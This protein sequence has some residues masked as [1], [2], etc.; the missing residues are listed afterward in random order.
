MFS[1]NHG[2]AI[3][4]QKVLRLPTHP[5]CRSNTHRDT[6]AV[7]SLSAFLRPVTVTDGECV[8]YSCIQLTNCPS[9]ITARH[10]VICERGDATG[11]VGGSDSEEAQR[12]Q[13][14]FEENGVCVGLQAHWDVDQLLMLVYWVRKTWNE[15][16]RWIQ[17]RSFCK[18]DYEN[19]IMVVHE[20]TP[21]KPNSARTDS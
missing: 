7:T 12:I 6:H 15:G 14:N 19:F 13:T 2:S 9:K 21:T 3:K 4:L 10:L 1:W 16:W 5:L 11:W 20:L 8:A 17:Q 18:V